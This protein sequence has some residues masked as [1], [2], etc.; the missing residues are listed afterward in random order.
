[1]ENVPSLKENKSSL[2]H[3]FVSGKQNFDKKIASHYLAF[4]CSLYCFITKRNISWKSTRKKYGLKTLVTSC[5]NLQWE[6]CGKGVYMY[7]CTKKKSIS[8]QFPLLVC[9]MTI[10][11]KTW[12]DFGVFGGMKN[13]TSNCFT[14]I[15]DS[16]IHELGKVP[17]TIIWNHLSVQI[18]PQ[19]RKNHIGNSIL[20]EMV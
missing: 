10:I 7:T 20:V 17:K 5:H 12:R 18:T 19:N 2:L 16:K 1:M 8:D 11:S 14:F 6:P 13:D 4:L 9:S 15:H 3:R